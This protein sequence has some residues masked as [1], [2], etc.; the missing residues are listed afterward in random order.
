MPTYQINQGTQHG[1]DST[2]AH[3]AVVDNTACCDN[4]NLYVVLIVTHGEVNFLSRSGE[5]GR[6]QARFSP[7]S[8]V[9]VYAVYN[10]RLAHQTMETCMDMVPGHERRRQGNTH[11][12]SGGRRGPPGACSRRGSGQPWPPRRGSRQY[13]AVCPQLY[14]EHAQN[15]TQNTKH[16]HTREKINLETREHCTWRV[17]KAHRFVGP[18]KSTFLHP[19]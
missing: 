16:E 14:S 9:L 4:T 13:I 12:P 8:Q 6:D 5:I 10:I 17:T 1:S 18:A 11:A 19:R 3:T 7:R 2:R 15:C